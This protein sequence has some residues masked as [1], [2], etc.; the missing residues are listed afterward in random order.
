MNSKKER[1][2]LWLTPEQSK[3]IKAKS[4]AA[5]FRNKSEY[6]RFMLLM[7]LSFIEKIDA[8]YKRVVKNE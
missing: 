5:G 1:Y 3:I 7:E 6:I 4:R 2:E 8:I